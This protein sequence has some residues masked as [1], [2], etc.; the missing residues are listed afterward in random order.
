MMEQ[1]EPHLL[2][3]HLLHLLP[4]EVKM[5]IYDNGCVTITIGDATMEPQDLAAIVTFAAF[6]GQITIEAGE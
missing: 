5:Q 2:E 1:P 4:I 3:E 6:H